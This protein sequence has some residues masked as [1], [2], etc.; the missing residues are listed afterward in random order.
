MLKC[1]RC[2]ANTQTLKVLWTEVIKAYSHNTQSA[3][4]FNPRLALVLAMDL[5]RKSFL[6][7]VSFV[8]FKSLHLFYSLIIYFIILTYLFQA[9]KDVELMSDSPVCQNV[10]IGVW[11]MPD[12]TRS[13]ALVAALQAKP[14]HNVEAF[15]CV[16]TELRSRVENK[17]AFT[18]SDSIPTKSEACMC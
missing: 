2:S 15:S 16:L 10:K 7:E 6:A 18:D 5:G 13:S 1:L 11:I 14:P 4:D 17:Y 8:A 12:G 9:L 3:L